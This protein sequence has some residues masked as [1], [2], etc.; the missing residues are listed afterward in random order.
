MGVRKKKSKY[1]QIFT[2]L[3]SL[4]IAAGI[5]YYVAKESDAYA[6]RH[7]PANNLDDNKLCERLF[8]SDISSLELPFF[9]S[10]EFVIHNAEGR[11]TVLY[12]TLYRQAAWVAY[13]LGRDD[14]DG[15]DV[16][17]RNKFIP[18]PQVVEKG[19]PT[20]KTGNYASSGY[21]RGHLCPSADRT[22]TQTENDCTFM[23]S[24]ISPQKPALNRGV[25]KNLEEQARHWAS[26]YDS[27]YIVTGGILSPGLKRI[28]GGVGVPEYFYKVFLVRSSGEF[29]AVGFIIPN[30]DD[31]KNDFMTYVATVDSLEKAVALDFFHNLPD[32]IENEVE[33]NDDFSVWISEAR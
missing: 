23:L 16:K 1:G 12:D 25:W 32:D 18:D 29:Y 2:A 15:S 26:A 11:Y 8:T 19:F 20:A 7:F 9:D 24:N 6:G 30:S 4:T 28:S 21:D 31:C 33:S 14:V 3:A 5:I 27:L 17:R 22:E 10:P 13:T